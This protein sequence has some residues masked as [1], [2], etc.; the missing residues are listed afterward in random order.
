QMAESLM[1][2]VPVQTRDFG[3]VHRKKRPAIED[4]R[5]S[6]DDNEEAL[7]YCDLVEGELKL[8]PSLLGLDCLAVAF[9]GPTG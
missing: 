6:P 1:P 8:K 5:E 3:L 2:E 9:T 4:L 7:L